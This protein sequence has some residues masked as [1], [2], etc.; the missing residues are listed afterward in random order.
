MHHDVAQLTLHM[1][2]SR[3]PQAARVVCLA[4]GIDDEQVA[5]LHAAH[6]GPVAT[7]NA[8]AEVLPRCFDDEGDRRATRHR[9]GTRHDD[10]GELAGARCGEVMPLHCAMGYEHDGDQHQQQNDAPQISFADIGETNQKQHCQ[11]AQQCPT[12]GVAWH[13][14]AQL[15]GQLDDERRPRRGFA[16]ESCGECGDESGSGQHM[17][18]CHGPRSE[19]NNMARVAVPGGVVA[20]RRELRRRGGVYSVIGA[21]SVALVGAVLIVLPGQLTGLVGFGLV[22][23]AC[24]LLVAFG[25]PLVVNV[26]SVGIGVLASLALWF[27]VGQW[28]ARRATQ[29]PIADWR[30]W[31]SVLWPLAIAVA[32][33]GVTGFVLFALSVL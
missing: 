26:G 9:V 6:R 11:Q 17:P 31:W 10:P 7:I 19:R 25:V 15:P 14:E 2:T 5:H 1:A 4:H 21:A 24:P 28:A 12:N 13:D 22:I 32:L 16:T 23:A 29:R 8:E 20:Y 3:K 33:G 30:D 18:R 27:V